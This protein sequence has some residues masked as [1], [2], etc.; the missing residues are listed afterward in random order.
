MLPL[1]EPEEQRRRWGAHGGRSGLSFSPGRFIRKNQ[2]T[3]CS[4]TSWTY[5]E[6]AGSS[7]HMVPR[8]LLIKRTEKRQL[9]QESKHHILVHGKIFQ[10]HLAP[11]T[12]CTGNKLTRLMSLRPNTQIYKD[13]V[14][15]I[16]QI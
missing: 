14:T 15:L 5:R 13:K 10:Q 11:R 1:W 6:E 16:M 12:W 7:D 4:R 2:A 8:A 3:H 9:K